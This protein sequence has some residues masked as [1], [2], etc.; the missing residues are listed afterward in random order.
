MLEDLKDRVKRMQDRCGGHEYTMLQ[1]FIILLI[2]MERLY[3][4]RKD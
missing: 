1:C 2:A 3:A 4:H